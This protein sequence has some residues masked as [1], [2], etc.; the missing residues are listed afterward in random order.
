MLMNRCCDGHFGYADLERGIV[1]RMYRESLERDCAAADNALCCS[2][3]S[4]GCPESQ[5][6]DHSRAACRTFR[7]ELSASLDVEQQS[8]KLTT[9]RELGRTT[10]P[11]LSQPVAMQNTR[12]AQYAACW[13]GFVKRFQFTL[14]TPR[15]H[16]LVSVHPDTTALLFSSLIPSIE[17]TFPRRELGA[18]CASHCSS[19]ATCR[20][21]STITGPSA[22]RAESL[23]R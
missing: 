3:D 13:V 15:F 22:A 8:I 12:P 19:D 18:G 23:T 16:A 20:E 7:H 17:T 14:P 1:F 2:S 9:E 5:R 21:S 10:E 11:P 6:N 4:L